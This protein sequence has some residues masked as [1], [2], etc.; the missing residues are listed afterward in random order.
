MCLGVPGTVKEVRN[1]VAL[2]E[3]YDGVIREVDATAV[4]DLRPGDFVIVHAGIIIGKI[5]EE[6]MRAQ[7]AYIEELI[8]DLEEKAREYEKLLKEEE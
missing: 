7:V 3:F 5:E 4:D 2:V 1:G 8:R 6:E